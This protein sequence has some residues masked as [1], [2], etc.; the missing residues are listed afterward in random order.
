MVPDLKRRVFLDTNVLFSALYSGKGP[1]GYI[2]DYFID[3][4]LS[5]VISQQV[6][7][8]VIRNMKLKLPRALPLFQQLLIDNPPVIVEIPSME[9]VLEWA[10]IINFE[11]AGVLA[12]AAAVQPDYLVTGDKHFFENPQIAQKSGLRIITPARFLVEFKLL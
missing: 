9:E 1:A 6:L 5:V 7:E 3:G 2:F 11:D 10:K 12:S 8:E 4:K